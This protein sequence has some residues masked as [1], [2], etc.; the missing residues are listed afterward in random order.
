M[1]DIQFLRYDFIIIVYQLR[2]KYILSIY[3]N[4]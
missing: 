2:K 3:S 4:Q 1:D